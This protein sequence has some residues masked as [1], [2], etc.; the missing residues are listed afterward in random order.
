LMALF[1]LPLFFPPLFVRL[2][3]YRLCRVLYKH[4]DLI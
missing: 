2:L 3:P 4:I 1:G